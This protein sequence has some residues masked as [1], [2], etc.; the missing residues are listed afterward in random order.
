MLL[1]I[2][3]CFDNITQ[4]KSNQFKYIETAKIFVKNEKKFLTSEM[5]CDSISK[6]TA[7]RST[8]PCKLNNVRQTKHLGQL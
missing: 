3:T 2:G 8:V 4:P 5:S 6:L 1:T 7:T